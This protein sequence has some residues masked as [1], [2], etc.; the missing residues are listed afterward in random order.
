MTNKTTRFSRVLALTLAFVIVLTGMNFGMWEGAGTAWAGEAEDTAAE[1]LRSNYIDGDAKVI[2]NGGEA[3]VKSQDGLS[4][5]VGLKTPSGG[6]ID[7]LRFKTEYKT[8]YKAGWSFSDDLKN[9]LTD[10]GTA[11][12]GRIR[13]FHRPSAEEGAYTFTAALKLYSSDTED[14]AINEG[15][16]EALAAQGFR[17][18]LLP[19]AKKL[20]VNFRILDSKTGEAVSNASVKLEDGTDAYAEKIEPN[21]AGNYI[22]EENLTYY[23]TV[24]AEGYNKISQQPQVFTESGTAEQ[25]MDP[26]EYAD[27]AFSVEGNDGAKLD[28]AEITVKDGNTYSAN[29]MTPTEGKYHLQKGK[30]YYVSVKKDG[31]RT[32]T[33]E[34]FTPSESGN[35]EKTY[36]LEKIYYSN[37]R[38]RVTD[39]NGEQIPDHTVSVKGKSSYGYFNVTIDAETDGCFKLEKNSEYQ[40]EVSA[41]NYAKKTETFTPAQ[42]NVE[43]EVTLEKDITEYQVEFLVKDEN[44]ERI[45]N[46]SIK[47]Y[48]ESTYFDPTEILPTDGKY[49]LAKGYSYSPNKFTYEIS[50]P[51]YEAIKVT[52]YMPSGDEANYTIPVTLKKLNEISITVIPVDAEIMISDAEKKE[53]APISAQDGVYQY[54]LKKGTTYTYKVSKFGYITKAGSFTVSGDLERTITLDEAKKWNVA[55]HIVTPSGISATPKIVIKEGQTVRAEGTAAAYELPNGNYSYSVSCDG[56]DESQG[57]FTVQDGDIAVDPITLTKKKSFADFFETVKD[58]AAVQNGTE[59]G[60][61]PTKL[62]TESVLASQNKGEDSSAAEILLTIKK[63][64]KFSFAYKVESEDRYD[65]FTVTK[66]TDVI[67]KDSGNKDWNTCSFEVTAG[68]TVTIKYE[69]DSSTDKYSD[70]VY[71]KA[72]TA[73]STA[74]VSF[75]NGPDQAVVTVKKNGEIVSDKDNKRCTLESGEY[76]YSVEAFGYQS[77][78]ETKLV[79]G[80]NSQTIDISMQALPKAKLTFSILPS[81]ISDPSIHVEHADAG[82]MS[83]FQKADGSFELP[84]N[85]TYTYTVSAPNYSS[86]SGQ[87]ILENQAQNITVTLQYLGTAWDGTSKTQPTQIGGF[88]QISNAAEL[89]WFAEQINAGNTSY[90]AKLTANINLNSKT[91][92]AIG[93]VNNPFAGVFDGKGKTISGLTDTNGLFGYVAADGTIKNLHLNCEIEGEGKLG[94]VVTEL[95]GTIED[96]TVSGKITTNTKVGNSMLGAFAGCAQ[97]TAVIKGCVNYAAVQNDYEK[98]GTALNTGGI[99]G[100][101]H[102]TVLNCYNVGSVSA[103]ED[104]TNRAVGGIVGSAESTAIIQN[105]YNIGTVSGPAAGIGAA[106]GMNSGSM[107]NTYYLQGT[108]ANAFA[109]NK[110]AAASDVQEKTAAEMKTDLFAFTLGDAFNKDTDNLNNGFPLLKWQGGSAPSVPQFEQD[111]ETDAAAIV[112]RDSDRVEALEAAKK[113]IR[114]EIAADGKQAA[115]DELNA[116]LPEGEEPKKISP[117]DFEKDYEQYLQKGLAL[118]RELYEEPELTLEDIYE[119]NDIDIHDDGALSPRQDGT[120]AA[121][122]AMT[123]DLPTSGEHGTK[124]AWSSSDPAVINAADG[125]IALPTSGTQTVTLTATVTK[126][127]Y[128]K[129]KE[130]SFVVRSQNDQYAE[131]LAEIKAKAEKTSTFIQPLQV[132]DH[133]NITQAMQQWIARQEYPVKG[134]DVFDELD[135]ADQTGEAGDTEASSKPAIKVTFVNAGTQSLP[136]NGVEYIEQETGKIEYFKGTEYGYATQYAIYNDVTFKLEYAGAETEVKVRAH[137]GWDTAYVEEILNKAMENVTWD[138]IKGENTNTAEER[139]EAGNS[140]MHTVVNGDVTNDLLLPYALEKFPYVSIKWAAVRQSVKNM[141]ALYVTDNGDGTYTA[142]LERPPLNGPANEFTLKA[143]ATFNFWDDYTIDEFTSMNGKEDPADSFKLFDLTVPANDNDQSEQINA[144]LEK[145]PTLLRDFVKKEQTVDSSAI[146]N[147]LQMPRPSVLQDAGIMPDSYNQK[148][149]MTSSKTDVLQ[150]NGYHAE[151]YRPLPGE[152]DA[153]VEYTIRILDRRNSTVLGEKTFTLTVKALTQTEIDDAAAWM[154]KISTES[155]YWNGIKGKNISKDQITTDLDPFV[156]ILR[157][158]NGEIIYTRGMGNITFGGAETDDLPGYDAMKPQPWREFRSS[159]HNI[160]ACETLQLTQPEYNTNIKIDSVLTDNTFGKYWKKFEGDARY[161]QFE[162]FY[163][164]PVAVVVTVIGTK[165]IPDPTPQPTTIQ[166]TV[167][168]DGKGNQGF[169][170]SGKLLIDGLEPDIAT[171][172]DAVIAAMKKANYHYDGF[173]DYIASVTDPNGVTLADTDTADSGWLYTVNGKLPGVYMGSYY[174]SN[175]D[176]IYLYYTADWKQDPNAG[177]WTELP[178]EVVTTGTSGSA[179]TT[180]PTEVKV[181]DKTAADGTKVKVAEVTVSADNQKEIIK[182]AKG[183]KSAEIVLNVNKA[184]VKDAACA[185]IKL[186]KSFLESIVKDTNAKLTIKTPFGDKTY[187]QDELKALLAG[188]NG[189]T[190]TLTI[191][192]SE[193]LDDAAKLAQAKE[194][195]AKVSLIARSAKTAKKNVKVTLKLNA[196]STAAINEIQSLGYTVKYKFYRS[197]KKASKYTAKLTKTSKSYLNT[198]GTKGS[199]Y[200]YKVRV[201][202]YDQ[203]GKLV[204]YSK[205]TQCKYAARTW[206]K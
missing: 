29:I 103:R 43:V 190:V 61:A 65:L 117:E 149:T 196:E 133:T 156:E 157:G 180:S 16:A 144:A 134:I 57:S 155:V 166:A 64:G 110:A 172:W 159:K 119:V 140:W 26:I 23:L 55:F 37:V 124:I 164:R 17:I 63:N 176:E 35:M 147:D 90:N 137:I 79:V 186:D 177:S 199:R 150:F 49:V 96:T 132:Y 68:D 202:V 70:T 28:D 108:A 203:D 87:V 54:A 165:G 118:W 47:V 136:K 162:Q 81:G 171:A 173:G 198:V 6:A 80:E 106:A 58:F 143:I 201:M 142:T 84:Q 27:V 94:A 91:W 72:F 12:S 46:C 51:G 191:E 66:N 20:E 24:E 123:L 50:A 31:Y 59:Y 135:T 113:A 77:I 78:P 183:N 205:L 75:I 102:G 1:Y 160:L 21:E 14:A 38:F 4:Y 56:C 192:K 52:G 148:V 161:A 146:T 97:K 107:I 179:V 182:Q 25:K 76:T 194:Q 39:K 105:S 8:A 71:L 86:V 67:V 126:G 33:N 127:S 48:R 69:K 85:E 36:V 151:I 122:H 185:D 13:E 40:Y 154:N 145:Y 163:K 62:G 60:F 30:N 206:T 9:Y 74:E 167:T 5:T 34:I 44:D 195:L 200:Y 15:T 114:D 93:T 169:R 139:Q 7:S 95:S 10:I 100:T 88:Y 168:I 158:E 131:I 2:S 189:T 45:S 125:K 115:E 89:A 98:Y 175:H 129:T 82:E 111:V 174:L 184:D 3:V 128:S 197:T 187:T 193:E 178:Q 101:L 170:S 138:S 120:Y 73:M 152:P 83:A 104:R 112:L 11:T 116:D 42:D 18:T 181:V 19:E 153:E 188:A 121:K 141:D 53:Q 92:T 109:D 32:I 99:V 41:K 22:V 204:A 130:F